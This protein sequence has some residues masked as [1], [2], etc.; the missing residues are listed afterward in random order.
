MGA[1]VVDAATRKRRLTRAVEHRGVADCHL[2][3]RRLRIPINFGV[4]VG[5]GVGVGDGDGVAGRQAS[6]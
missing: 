3:A 4:G 6:E 1:Q 5:V 2:T